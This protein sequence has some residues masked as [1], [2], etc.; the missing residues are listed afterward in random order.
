[1]QRGAQMLWVLCTGFLA[2]VFAYSLVPVGTAS[3]A[4]CAL[5]GLGVCVVLLL[6]KRAGTSL[7]V[8][9]FM[10]AALIGAWRTDAARLVGD[11]SLDAHIGQN[12]VLEGVVN[13]EPDVREG[14][15]RL[16]AAIER[17]ASTSAPVHAGVLAV[18]P[19]Y[20][21][22]QYGDRIRVRGVVALPEAFDTGSGRQFDYPGYLAVSGIGYQLQHASA[23]VLEPAHTTFTGIA[24]ALKQWY[25]RGLGAALIE[26]QAGL[27]AGITAG[28]KRG[29]GK[30][31]SEEFR[32]VSLTHIIV[33]SGYN[34]TV[35]ADAA[36]RVLSF[37]PPLVRFGAAGTIALFFAVMTGG[38]AASVR[39][40]VMALI[41]MTAKLSGRIYRADRALAVAAAGMAAWNPLVVVHDPGYQL[42]LAATAG[43]IWLSPMV[44][45]W[46]VR[47]PE[48]WGLRAVCV[49]TLSAQIA[50]APLIL[51]SSGLVSFVA[52]PANILILA[53]IPLAMFWSLIAGLAGSILGLIAPV[54]ALPA[55]IL[56]SYVLGVAHLL[57]SLPFASVTLPAFSPAWVEAAYVCGV[58]WVAHAHTETAAP[59]GAAATGFFVKED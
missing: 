35:V 49:S 10:C 6:E 13:A 55:H 31:V 30:D 17:V 20:A 36:M 41:A 52:L 43:L 15:V 39:A 44:E 14:S 48:A 29:L 26:P 37:A 57:A 53:V 27:A 22:V 4:F 16:S 7:L 5:L 12:V 42:S 33:L 11:T 54:F 18:I 47:V 32:T 59:K 2:G 21:P 40:A 25:V 9:A 34:I 50:V 3:L 1:M 45:R 24:I 28:D 19:A 23:D 58:L 51:Y 8:C 38:A 56:L 46:C